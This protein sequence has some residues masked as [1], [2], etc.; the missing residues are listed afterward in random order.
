MRQHRGRPPVRAGA[1]R[2]LTQNNEEVM[3]QIINQTHDI[4]PWDVPG[5]QIRPTAGSFAFMLDS[6]L[7]AILAQHSLGGLGTGRGRESASSITICVLWFTQHDSKGSPLK[8]GKCNNI[9]QTTATCIG[10]TTAVDF[11]TSISAAPHHFVTQSWESDL[12][13][14]QA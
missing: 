12:L 2:D 4:F 11:C 14:N 8:P 9:S 1:R 10:S 3:Q 5:L 7:K 13:S 6:K